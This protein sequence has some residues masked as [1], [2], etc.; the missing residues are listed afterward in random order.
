MHIKLSKPI[1]K[2]RKTLEEAI[3]ARRTIRKYDTGAITPEQLATLCWAGQGITAPGRGYR[4]APSAGALYPIFLYVALGEKSVPGFDSATYVYLPKEH[5]LESV[6]KGD[7][8]RKLARA[9]L[10]QMWMSHAAVMFLVAA[11]FKIIT[12]KY[13]RRG[14]PYAHYEAGHVAENIL[15]EA[16]ALDLGAGIVG[17]F[18]DDNIAKEAGVAKG[19]DPML[20]L[21]VG[22]IAKR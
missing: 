13:G 3:A 18:N 22:H 15:L 4:A 2:G 16:V 10:E 19:R 14:I 6:K 8:R 20:L 17:A 21:P 5:A 12:P 9:S 11:D 7:A 1:K